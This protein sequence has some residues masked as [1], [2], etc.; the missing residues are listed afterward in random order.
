[1]TAILSIEMPENCVDCPFS[2]TDNTICFALD[3]GENE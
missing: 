2:D 1:M 3:N